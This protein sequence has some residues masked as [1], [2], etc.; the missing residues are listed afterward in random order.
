ML[1][2]ELRLRPSAGSAKAFLPAESAKACAFGVS[3][4]PLSPRGFPELRAVR[5][6]LDMTRDARSSMLLCELSQCSTLCTLYVVICAAQ[7]TWSQADVGLCDK[8]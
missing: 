1:L 7:S 6:R 2:P 4:Q 5:E 3:T 8:P